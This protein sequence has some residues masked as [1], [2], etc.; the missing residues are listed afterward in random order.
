[1]ADHS[2]SRGYC[3][4]WCITFAGRKGPIAARLESASSES[5]AVDGHIGPLERQCYGA[6]RWM[7]GQQPSDQLGP[8][9]N[10]ASVS[11]RA[12]WKQARE[13][14]A[15]HHYKRFA[16]LHLAGD[17]RRNDEEAQPKW[18]VKPVETIN[19]CQV[20]L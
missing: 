7:L 17:S 8:G 15:R 4:H 9:R 6:Q 5:R 3:T 18:K 20:L 10:H 12:G 13:D 11:G 19:C 2:L 16:C 14:A 1:M